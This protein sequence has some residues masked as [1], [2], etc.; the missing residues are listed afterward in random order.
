MAEVD[1][2]SVEAAKPFDYEAVAE[3]FPAR[4]QKF[5][6][7][8]ARYRRFESAAEALRFAMEEMPPK[9]LAGAWLEVEEER[10]DADA[11]RR[12]YDSTEFPL[13]GRRPVQ[14]R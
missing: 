4:N 7:E 11:M 9:S 12:L 3:L 13:A 10:F 14:V 6:R 5:N 1:P 8:F 2:D